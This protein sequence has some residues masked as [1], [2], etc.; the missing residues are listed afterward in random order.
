M[1]TDNSR[2]NFYCCI[3]NFSRTIVND[4]LVKNGWTSSGGQSGDFHIDNQWSDLE[5]YGDENSN[6]FL[7]GLLTNSVDSFKILTGHLRDNKVKFQAELYNN[8]NEI[9]LNDNNTS[10]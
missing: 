1:T 5:L 2:N 7:N 4:I 8:K 9:I 3:D 10:T 6:I